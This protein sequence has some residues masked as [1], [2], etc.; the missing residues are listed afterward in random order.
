MVKEYKFLLTFQIKEKERKREKEK[1][2]IIF[3]NIQDQITEFGA[4]K[5]YIFFVKM[6]QLKIFLQFSYLE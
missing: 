6:L 2:S 3:N 4:I 5:L 1:K